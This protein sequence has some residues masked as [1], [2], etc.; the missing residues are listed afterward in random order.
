[1]RQKAEG[2]RTAGLKWPGLSPK[3][4]LG[5]ISGTDAQREGGMTTGHTLFADLCTYVLLFDQT[6]LQGEFQ[7]S[8]EQV[9]RGTS[10]RFPGASALLVIRPLWGLRPRSATS[11]GA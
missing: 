10:S 6:H 8:Y 1:M 11:S 7:P 3:P 2:S 5:G 4:D 9:R